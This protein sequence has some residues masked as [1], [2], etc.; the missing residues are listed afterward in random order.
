[1]TVNVFEHFAHK[2]FF[3]DRKCLMG[4]AT[5]FQVWGM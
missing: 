3:C 1:V 4:Y 2:M 5:S